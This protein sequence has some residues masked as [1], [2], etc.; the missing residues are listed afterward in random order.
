V[1][2]GLARCESVL[3]WR[4]PEKR[5]SFLHGKEFSS[6]FFIAFKESVWARVTS[7][8]KMIP[9]ISWWQKYFSEY[10][11]SNPRISCTLNDVRE[12]VQKV[13]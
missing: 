13:V 3:L 8:K 7:Y 2:G 1:E 5:R 6:K 12:V 11:I 4:P 9:E 10:K